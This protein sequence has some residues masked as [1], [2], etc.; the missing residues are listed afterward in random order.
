MMANGILIVSICTHQDEQTLEAGISVR[1]AALRGYVRLVAWLDSVF[2]GPMQY[3][4]KLCCL[5]P[6]MASVAVSFAE[7]RSK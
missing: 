5:C 4:L 3:M 1:C 2:T 7:E 6:C